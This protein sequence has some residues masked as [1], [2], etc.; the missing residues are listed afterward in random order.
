[1]AMLHENLLCSRSSSTPTDKISKLFRVR[2]FE[3]FV[4]IQMTRFSRLHP[5]PAMIA[6]ELVADLC[7][8]YVA[9]NNL[10]LDPFCGTGRTLVAA[11]ERGARAIGIDINPLAVLV[12]RAKANRYAIAGLSSF[13]EKIVRRSGRTIG[14]TKVEFEQGRRVKWFSSKALNE[15]AAIIALLNRERF[16][17]T[18]LQLLGCI[19]SATAREVSFCRK[20]QWK[21]HRMNAARRSAFRKSAWAIFASRLDYVLAEIKRSERLTGTATAFWGSSTAPERLRYLG[22]LEGQFDLSITSPPYGDSQTT[23]QYGGISSLCLGVLNHLS[24]LEIPLKSSA[25]IDERCLGGRA[26][27]RALDLSLTDAQITQFWAGPRNGHRSHVFSFLEDVFTS[28]QFIVRMLKRGGGA[29]FVVGRRN[30]AMHQLRLDEFLIRTMTILGC[31]LA[32]KHRRKIV[33]KMTPLVIDRAGH[34]RKPHT[35]SR[36]YVPTIRHE[37][38]LVFRKY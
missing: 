35:G 15:L 12:S 27:F 24:K 4:T 1:M 7:K 8:Q 22:K 14:E 32:S 10:V 30:V 20:D 23:V 36:R 38:I 11:A 33:G 28:C 6:D 19:L 31:K 2:Y 18:E 34:C 9:P 37:Y 5:Y 25:W 21:I 13:R 29:I 3:K 16:R 26:Q 17:K